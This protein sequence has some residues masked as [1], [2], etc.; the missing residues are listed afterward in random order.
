LIVAEIE[1]REE[2]DTFVRPAWLGEEVTTDP[3]YLNASLAVHP[4]SRPA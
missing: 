3:R 2:S 1:L 4:W